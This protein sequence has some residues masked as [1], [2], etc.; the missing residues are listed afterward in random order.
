M[1]NYKYYIDIT[2]I[3]DDEVGLGFIWQ[4]VYKQIH[5]LLADNKVDKHDSSI[6][7]SF[8]KY[9]DKSFPLGDKLRIMAQTKEELIEL[10]IDR[11]LRRINY[12]IHIKPIK[13]VPDGINKFVCFKRKQFK[14]PGKI[15]KNIEHR[16]KIIAEKNNLDFSEVKNNL[17]ST[18]DNV[19]ESFDYPFINVESLSSGG[20]TDPSDRK[21][22]K[23]FIERQDAPAA[24]GI[25]RFTCYGLS[26]RSR[27]EQ[28][29][30]PW[31]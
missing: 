11:C 30:V 6:G 14:S 21:W 20:Q 9:G 16:A 29:P 3:P 27:G 12:Y 2:L 17:L 1:N 23:L 25:R 19:K 10:K 15:R 13:T 8:P 24:V 26:R 28:M 18:M 4:K 7:L 22:F 31:F 5:I